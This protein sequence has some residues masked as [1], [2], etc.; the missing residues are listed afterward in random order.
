MKIELG[1]RVADKL[2][3]LTGFAVAR[4]EYLYGCSRVCVQPSHTKDGKPADTVWIDE[5][6]L[7]VLDNGLLADA[8]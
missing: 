5:P 7:E 4:A 3:G 1:Q 2:T 6:Q 8:R